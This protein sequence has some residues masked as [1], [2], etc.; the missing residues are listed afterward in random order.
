MKIVVP[1]DIA[2][3][4]VRLRHGIK[5]ESGPIGFCS[6][7]MLLQSELR[8]NVKGDTFWLQCTR[9]HMINL[10]QRCFY[11][12]LKQEGNSTTIEGK[13]KLTRSYKGVVLVILGCFLIF[14]ICAQLTPLLPLLVVSLSLL[15]PCFSSIY[16]EREEAT[17]ISFLQR[18]GDG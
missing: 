14:C 3:A 11:G 7:P 8:G 16:Y 9:P 18:Q 10:P 2:E 17:V 12:T 1:Y 15:A 4:R 5:I 6:M 13:F